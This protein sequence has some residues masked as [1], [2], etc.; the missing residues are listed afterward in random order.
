M[1]IVIITKHKDVYKGNMFS[2]AHVID[3]ASPKIDYTVANSDL[4]GDGLCEEDKEKLFEYL[5]D[6]GNI[7]G[8]TVEL[9]H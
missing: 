3:C 6:L 9:C 8:I 1:K 5:R 2:I 4:G 7:H